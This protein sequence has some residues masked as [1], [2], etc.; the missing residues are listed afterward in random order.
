MIF[1]PFF[2]P[3]SDCTFDVALRFIWGITYGALMTIGLDWIFPTFE[4]GLE[5]FR[6]M[7]LTGWLICFPP[8]DITFAL[9]FPVDN[10]DV[11]MFWTDILFNASSPALVNFNV[12]SLDNI[13]EASS[14]GKY[15]MPWDA[16]SLTASSVGIGK[17]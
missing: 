7:I 5:L 11:T 17:R 12:W 3:A 2:S 10:A 14:S 8:V 9:E 6:V 13:F 1:G 16:K 4:E 15:V